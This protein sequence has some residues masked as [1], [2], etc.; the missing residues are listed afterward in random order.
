MGYR[1]CTSKPSLTYSTRERF[2]H[3]DGSAPIRGSSSARCRSSRSSVPRTVFGRSPL[4]LPRMQSASVPNSPVLPLPRRV[5]A[6][7]SRVLHAVHGLRPTSRGSAPPLDRDEAAEFTFVAD[8][9]LARPCGLCHGASA[10]GSPLAPAVSYWAARS[11]PRRDFHPQ[12]GLSLSGHTAGRRST[13][14]P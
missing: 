6:L 12:V 3:H 9:T 1:T 2:F 7:H 10:L 11:L 4:V 13:P 5:T 14:H 8:H